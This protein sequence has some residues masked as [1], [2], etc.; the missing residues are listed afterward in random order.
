MKVSVV[1]LP[2]G[3]L[4]A[5]LE[6]AVERVLDPHRQRQGRWIHR[7]DRA[8]PLGLAW[9]QTQQPAVVQ[10]LS[11]WGGRVEAEFFDPAQFGVVGHG[12]IQCSRGFS[13][14]TTPPLALI[15]AAFL[16]IWQGKRHTSEHGEDW[17]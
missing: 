16:P 13:P 11:R 12:R 9:Q 2:S 14:A 5:H 17:S 15:P 6:E 3:V 7:I 4:A 8:R 10:K 1:K